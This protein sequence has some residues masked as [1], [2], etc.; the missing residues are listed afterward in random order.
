MEIIAHQLLSQELNSDTGEGPGQ[1]G[2]ITRSVIATQKSISRHVD[3]QRCNSE[4]SYEGP[5]QSRGITRSELTMPNAKSALGRKGAKRKLSV[6]KIKTKYRAIMEVE[7]GEKSKSTIAKN[8]GV[9]FN[10]LSTWLKKKESIIDAYQQFN[11]NRINTRYST[12]N[13]VETAALKLFKSARDKNIPIS[14]PMLTAKDEEY[15]EKLDITN[16]KASVGWLENFKSRQGISFKR[17]CGE[18]N[19]KVH[20]RKRVLLK[21]I[22]S[23]DRDETRTSTY[24]T[25]SIC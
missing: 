18:E 12:F 8:L 5:G 4:Q 21:F 19:L 16:F 20:Y 24:L 15:A 3:S 22:R 2:G 17:V 10:T 11:P 7:Q 25:P 14:S 13:D 9:P 1:Y 6:K 23:I